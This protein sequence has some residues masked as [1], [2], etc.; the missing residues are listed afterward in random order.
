MAEFTYRR[1]RHPQTG[2]HTICLSYT[3]SGA[4]TAQSTARFSTDMGS[5]LLG[6][7][8]DGIEYLYSGPSLQL[9]ANMTGTPVLYPTPNRVRDGQ[10]TFEGR[11]FKFAP[12]RGIGHSHGLVRNAPWECDEPVIADGSILATTRIIFEPGKGWYEQFPI[13]H[14]LELTYTLKPNTLRFDFAVHNQDAQRL[15]FGLAIHPYFNVIG[16]RES[17]RIQI[18]ALKWMENINMFPTGRLIDLDKCPTDLRKPTRLSEIHHDGVFWGLSPDRPQVI[19]YDSIGKKLTLV[20]SE[21]FTHMVTYTPHRQP[22]FCI[23]NQSCSV[24]AHNHHVRGFVEQAHLTILEPD[25]K[26]AARI[27]MSVSDQ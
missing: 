12:T 19:Y 4:A 21:L 22:F 10:F 23:E 20:A 24:D 2:W 14:T 16:P 25:K 18:P 13:R 3:P 11:T 17:V 7:E 8:V 6:F 5:N 1:E 26:L 9:G 27:E 15:P